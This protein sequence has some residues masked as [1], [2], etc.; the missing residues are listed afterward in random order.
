MS[1]DDDD[2]LSI[3]EEDGPGAD[4]DASPLMWR[5]LI[6][7]DDEDVHQATR[8]ALSSTP[9]LGRPLHF[10]H[11]YSAAEAKDLL[12]VER[13]IA[14]ML[15]DVVMERED[16]GLQLVQVVRG[17]LGIRDTRIILRT[18]QPGYAPEIEA[19]RDYD[20]NDYKTK[21]DLSRN[22]LYTALT[23]AIR[24]YEQI[25]AL[26]LSRRGLDQ[27][28][29]GSGELMARHTL[30]EFAAGIIEQIAELLGVAQDGLVV[31]RSV[32]ESLA[33]GRI[34][35]ASGRYADC[36]DTTLASLAPPLGSYLAAVMRE[37]QS[38]FADHEI[39]LFIGGESGRDMVVHI[40]LAKPLSD[41]EKR[42]LDVFCANIAISLDN[43]ILFGR[44]SDHAYNDQLLRIPNRLA[45]V[46]AVGRAVDAGR[47]GDTVAVVDV[48]H[49]SELNDALGHRYGDSLLRAVARR[50][51]EIL[52]PD[53]MVARVAADTFGILGGDDKVTPTELLRLFARP[54]AID[55][56]DHNITATIGLARLGEVEGNGSDVFKAANIA[57]NRAKSTSRGEVCYFTPAMEFETRARVRLLQELRAAFNQDRLFVVYQPQ[58]E[59]PSRRVIGVE[60]LLRWR[61]DDGHFVPP[62][63]FIPLAENSGLIIGLGE[64]VLRSACH[65]LAAFERVGLGGLRMA[66]NV[67]VAQF[68]HPSFLPTVDSIL[69][70]TGIDPAALELE[71]TESMAM[72]DAD[73]MVDML[74]R[75]KSRGLTVAVDDFGTGF[76]SLS[77]LERLNID[78][79]KIDRSFIT[80]MNESESGHRIAE[81][82]VR[83]GKSLDLTV[84]AEGV[85]DERQL[86]RLEELGCHEAQGYLF[87]RPL[88]VGPLLEFL[89]EAARS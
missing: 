86:A 70:K 72:L 41:I 43:V 46:Q 34:A 71:I 21:S 33:A 45:F 65:Q 85:E 27:I 39:T 69:A 2:I 31:E 66:V 77:Y 79:L 74:N 73:F 18:G 78:R 23:A 60:A 12:S 10:L 15:L 7:D 1:G 59:L 80:Q 32:S 58:V 64:W 87:A 8:F 54:F 20:I 63:Q 82:I 35:A 47:R 38:A 16:A 88:E 62:T 55:G 40:P 5:V 61:A 76:S 56:A 29:R 75:L 17:E 81:T 6:V 28:V 51:T 9:I 42:L 44:L 89:R 11:A 67:S 49:F 30:H 25:H 4:G 48:D 37:R 52:P 19:I 84:I 26:N 53:V 68:R 22:R 3:L 13:D 50:L 36:A 57:L 24:S 83:L 14:V